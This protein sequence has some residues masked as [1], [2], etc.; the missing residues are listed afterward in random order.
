[1]GVNGHF[2]S[3]L[4]IQNLPVIHDEAVKGP[5][6]VR[7]ASVSKMVEETRPRNLILSNFLSPI[8]SSCAV[9]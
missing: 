5:E 3:F 8:I 9:I 4:I 6:S 2:A 7:L 1:M